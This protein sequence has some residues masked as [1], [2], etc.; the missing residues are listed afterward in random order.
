MFISIAILLI[1]CGILLLLKATKMPKEQGL[2]I[3]TGV[4]AVVMI[5]FGVVLTYCLLSGII[6]LPLH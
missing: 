2:H 6:V 5:I 3:I 4:G 1:I